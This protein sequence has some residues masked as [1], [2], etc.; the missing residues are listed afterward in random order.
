[1]VV[2][3]PIDVT[4]VI[5]TVPAVCEGDVAVIDPE[6]FTVYEPREPPNR[7]A[8]TLLNPV[9]LMATPVPPSVVPE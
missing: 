2:E 4:T 7:T 1:M 5:S 6:E 3:L 9:P 8:E